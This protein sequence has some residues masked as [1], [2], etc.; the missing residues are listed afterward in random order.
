[1]A[2]QV[3]VMRAI[4][5]AKYADGLTKDQWFDLAQSQEWH[6]M[7][8]EMADMVAPFMKKY[9]RMLPGVGG[10]GNGNEPANPSL[11]ATDFSVLG[12][13]I[14][15]VQ[16]IGIVTGLGKYAQHIAPKN[17]LFL[18]TLRSP[19]PHAKVVKVDTSKAEKLA[20]VVGVLHRGNLPKEYQDVRL[21]GGPPLR[22]V[23]N[24]EVYEVGAPIVCIAA[25]S[26]HIADEAVHLIEVQY[27]VLTPALN[28]LDAMKPATAKQWDNKFDGTIIDIPTPFKRGDIAKGMTEAEV[29]VENSSARATEQHMPLEMTTTI[30]WWDNDKYTAIYT[31][32]HAHGSRNGLAQA[33]KLPQHKVRVIQTGYMGSGYGYRSGVDLTEVHAA[34]MARLTGRPV[35]AMYTR[36]EDFIIRT[37]RPENF[38]EMKL[39]VKR[40]G[41]IVAGQFKVIANV[42]PQRAA[43][44]SGSW[45]NMQYMYNIPNLQVEGVDVFTNRFKSG[46]YR[47]VGHPNGTLALETIMDIAAYKIGMDPVAF[48]LKNVNMYG[49]VDAKLPYSNPGAITVI[50]EAAKTIG[51]AQKFHAPKAKEVR[52]GV[53]HGIG[54]ASTNCNHGA[55]SAPST[56][57]LIINT[58][59]TVNAI[60][61]ATDIGPGQKTQM[62]MIAAE[63]LGVPLENV[64]IAYE[65]DTDFSPDTGVTAGSRQTNSGG[66]G[67]YQAAADAR[68]QALDFA[69]RKFVDDARRATPPQTITVS[70]DE[71]DLQNGEIFFKTNPSRKMLL[72]DAVQFSGQ[73]ILGRGAHQ[74]STA[75]FR[76]AHYAHAAEVEVDTTTGSIKV[77]KYVAAHD[78]GKAMNP[79]ALEQQIEGGVVMG[80]GAALSEELLIDQA[81]GLPLNDNILD[82]KALSIK[83]VPRTID[84]VLVE[85][86]KAYGVYGAH[87][88]GE[89]PINPPAAVIANAVYNAIGVRVDKTPITREKVLAALKAA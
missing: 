76:V 52:P 22:D 49:N 8:T 43:A 69:A 80:L 48:R 7:V 21:G 64:R 71:L 51:W 60:S 3:D 50:N 14:P 81:T 47:C 33:L 31:C 58:D 75:W 70:A 1:M 86:E 83:D 67:M 44:A 17:A 30:G 34:I 39:G 46:P 78:V 36:A 72:R 79:F 42:G 6:L 24:E 19:H 32:Q 38:N 66:W 84:V 68:R 9:E 10:S 85:H 2:K 62:A 23:F 11:A 26:D 59:G 16:G 25:E 73:P 61:G 77:I 54:F 37:H 65:T 29:V 12:K 88:I 45:Y 41:T 74:Q 63:T 28:T 82:Y 56:G 87:G 55:G 53:F 20:G 15:R 40:D 13:R 35:R 5:D 57:M 18:K 27:Q 89:P 4:Q